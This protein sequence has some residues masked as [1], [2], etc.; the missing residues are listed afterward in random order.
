MTTETNHT[1]SA[2]P[3]NS[4]NGHKEPVHDAPLSSPAAMED[5]PEE[6]S[7]PEPDQLGPPA[8][9]ASREDS[10]TPSESAQEQVMTPTDAPAG[11]DPLLTPE[12]ES[13]LLHRWTEIQISFVEN[14]RA[15]VQDADA[16]V[17]QITTTLLAS[18][19]ER[20]SLLAAAWQWQDGQPD[21]EQL[22][23]ALRQY[24][25]FIGVVLPIGP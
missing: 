6:L 22:R 19:Q 3:G 14:P 9:P 2:E 21:T 11:E 24:R 18:I 1:L 10:L 17:Q 7:G 23:L 13:D 15:S 5:A 25:S 4:W 16:L 8:V 12:A 20:R